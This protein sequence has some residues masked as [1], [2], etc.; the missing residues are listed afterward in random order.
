[1]S[2]EIPLTARVRVAD[3]VLYRDLGEDLV[4]LDLRSGIYFS[5]DPIGARI[6][7]LL[8]R[9]QPLAAVLEALVGE[10]DVETARCARDLV[11]LV[12]ELRDRG[13]VAVDDRA[14]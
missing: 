5:L 12:T 14:A 11:R 13:L 2:P 9:P 8:R 6:W 3:H 4:L 1:M 10:Y 7:H